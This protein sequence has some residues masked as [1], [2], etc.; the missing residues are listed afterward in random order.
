MK[1]KKN[2]NQSSQIVVKN[3]FE[4]LAKLQ[5]YETEG[6]NVK[7]YSKE[8]SAEERELIV[9]T[10]R[11]SE[12]EAR[13]NIKKAD[14]KKLIKNKK[15]S[16]AKNK[17]LDSLKCFYFNARSI[18][19]KID[20]LELYLTQEKPDIVGITETWTYEDIEDSEI[21]MEGY[22]LLRKESYW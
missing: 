14:K 3:K 20:E 22:T 19:N 16:E 13:G 18:M 9:G 10:M 4:I 7:N 21:C 6:H 11:N 5:E 8:L 2:T 15:N 12:R 1:N 17:K